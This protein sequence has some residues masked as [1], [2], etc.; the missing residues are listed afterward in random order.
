M[1]K[2][3]F[4]EEIEAY[5]QDTSGH[6]PEIKGK[7]ENDRDTMLKERAAEDSSRL[8]YQE[9][10]ESW[11]LPGEGWSA[12]KR[13]SVRKRNVAAKR[14]EAELVLTR[15]ERIPLPTLIGRLSG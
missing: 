13:A 10:K 11:S 15:I 5:Y 8:A 12:S 3:S 7:I 6:Y 9:G 2:K 4:M 1:A 14:P